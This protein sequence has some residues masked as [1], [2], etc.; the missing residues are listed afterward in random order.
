MRGEGAIGREYTARPM[1][2]A[3]RVTIRP[4]G[5]YDINA[6]H[7]IE[8]G[9]RDW[10]TLAGLP[11]P[12]DP[13]AVAAVDA[14]LSTIAS[15]PDKLIRVDDPAGP[16]LA[17]V[18]FQSGADVDFDRRVL[19]YNVLAGWRHRLPVRSVAYL[20]RPAAVTP[21][22]A[23]GVRECLD[24]RSRLEF[25]YRLVRVWE[26]PV[27]AV[28]AGGLGTLP[29][30]PVTAVAEGDLPAVVERMRVRLDREASPRSA[31]ELWLST[32]ILLGLHHDRAFAAALLKGVLDMRESTTFQ[33]IVEIGEARGEALGNS[34]AS[35]APWSDKGRR[36]SDRRTPRSW[37]GWTR[38]ATSPNSTG[39]ASPY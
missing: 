32:R 20:L 38:S 15:A 18:E 5:D 34:G 28:L 8:G 1:P 23:G 4:M 6:K 2:A 11:V 31:R 10:L 26:L 39:S 13:A 14:D 33:E 19:V 30:A 12:A 3:N 22:L 24:D 21:R 7:L 17:H 16:Y 35:G 37:P 9:P 27:E 29:L 36:G 25:D